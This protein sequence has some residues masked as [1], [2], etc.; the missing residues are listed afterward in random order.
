[1]RGNN[2]L[3]QAHSPDGEGL[4]D[5]GEGEGIGGKGGGGGG[6]ASGGPGARGERDRAGTEGPLRGGDGGG[7]SCGVA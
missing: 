3:D 7:R 6:A 4:S 5:M 2:E 1:M